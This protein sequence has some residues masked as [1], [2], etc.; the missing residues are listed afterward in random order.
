MSRIAYADRLLRSVEGKAQR[1]YHQLLSKHT[2]L[3]DHV[4]PGSPMKEGV[5]ST[6]D[7]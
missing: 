7:R 5:L 6:W 1:N 3:V 4:A 2:R